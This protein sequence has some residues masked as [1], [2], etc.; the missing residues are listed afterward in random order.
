MPRYFIIYKPYLV[1][2]QF[3]SDL[4]K[5]TL[6]DFFDVPKD[7]YPVGRLDND[8]EGL[9]LLTNDPSV[10]HRL[11]DPKF[12]H[13]RE[14]LVQ[15]DGS[16]T[17]QA[18]Q[19]LAQGVQ[20]NVDGKAYRTKPCT[21]KLL[22]TPPDVAQRHPPIRVRKEIPAPWIRIVLREGKNRQ[23]RKMCAQVGFPVLRLIR[24][25]MEN[26]QLGDMRPGDITELPQNL[27]MEGL[28]NGRVS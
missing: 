2:S 14:Y 17:Q 4:G 23:V 16:I 26:I 19:Q 25:R 18:A 10:N 11:L 9:L 24:T 5:Q 28:F 22:E 27:L 6:A 12:G 13:A 20:I 8:S 15:V 1:L 3:T 7:V 21:A